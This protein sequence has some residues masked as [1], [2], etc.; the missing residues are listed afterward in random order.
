MTQMT[1]TPRDFVYVPPP[2]QENVNVS[3]L[4]SVPAAVAA[5]ST[6]NTDSIIAR[7]N[8]V[9]FDNIATIT[10]A[11]IVDAATNNSMAKTVQNVEGVMQKCL[12]KGCKLYTNQTPMI[13]CDAED[14]VTVIVPT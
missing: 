10:T 2:P 13:T 3:L 4:P 1:D 6:N 11:A 7:N 12:V 5:A 14:L 8:N 9:S